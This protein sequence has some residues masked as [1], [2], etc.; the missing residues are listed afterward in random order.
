[1]DL[2]A[3]GDRLSVQFWLWLLGFGYW[4]IADIRTPKAPSD[5]T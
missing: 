5:D 1:M 4:L 3:V 2:M